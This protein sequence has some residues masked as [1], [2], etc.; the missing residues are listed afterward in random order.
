MIH[1]TLAILSMM[2]IGGCGL[3]WLVAVLRGERT[4][5]LPFIEP[6][7]G[8]WFIGI[9]P[10]FPMTIF[11]VIWWFADRPIRKQ[12]RRRKRKKLGLCV[13]CG[14]DLRASKD[15]CPECGEGFGSTIDGRGSSMQT[16]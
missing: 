13:K 3:L 6:S 12:N 1:K 11:G 5:F 16:Q 8:S 10:W 4:F 14:Y 9:P 2:G 7:Q 15:R